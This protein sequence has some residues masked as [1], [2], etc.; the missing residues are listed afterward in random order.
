MKLI[1]LSSNLC[2]FG[3]PE[4][5][6]LAAIGD[7]DENIRKFASEKILLARSAPSTDDVRCFDK[8]TLKINFACRSYVDMIDWD[9]VTFDSPPLLHDIASDMIASHSQVVLPH[10]PCHSQDVERNIKDVS[11]VCHKVYGHDSRHGVVIQ[12]K[13]SRLDV[14]AV[15][16]KA[17]FLK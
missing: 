14:P 2:Y 15:E 10:Y 11:S 7:D 12:I 17:D 1:S 5:I 3:H 8:N 9:S 16:T 13:K 4:N 6:L